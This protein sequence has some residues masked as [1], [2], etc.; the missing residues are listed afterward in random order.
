MKIKYHDFVKH[1][2]HISSKII[3]TFH[4]FSIYLYVF[5]AGIKLE[6][7]ILVVCTTYLWLALFH[8]LMPYF[9]KIVPVVLFLLN[10][11][12]ITLPHFISSEKLFTDDLHRENRSEVRPGV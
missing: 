12:N 7:T 5:R 11:L 1:L 2:A 3:S 4:F 6:Y 10:I 9:D 8:Y